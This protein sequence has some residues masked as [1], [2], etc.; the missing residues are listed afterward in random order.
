ML[1]LPHMLI[2]RNSPD[3]LI[4]QAYE[5]RTE[6]ERQVL[7]E[8]ATRNGFVVQHESINYTEETSPGWRDSKEWKNCLF[9]RKSPEKHPSFPVYEI[10]K[11]VKRCGPY[12][13]GGYRDWLVACYSVRNLED[14]HGF[15]PVACWSELDGCCKQWLLCEKD[16]E[17]YVDYLS[18]NDMNRGYGLKPM[19]VTEQ[20]Y[21]P[22]V[23]DWVFNEL[24]R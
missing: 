7:T 15:T 24:K 19:K 2:M 3:G 17:F 20:A 9:Y 16:G 21:P 12:W 4:W 14:M 1:E 22:H 10:F 18:G 5:V 6:Q 8:N 11:K 13:L 23:F